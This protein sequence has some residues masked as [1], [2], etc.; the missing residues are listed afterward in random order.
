[1]EEAGIVRRG[2]N[3]CA[4]ERGIS[5][6]LEEP[7]PWQY[8]CITTCTTEARTGRASR[9]REGLPKKR[10]LDNTL[11]R[12]HQESPYVGHKKQSNFFIDGYQQ[13]K[14]LHIYRM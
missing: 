6:E 9:G 4:G 5:C 2:I 12:R 8:S 14:T 1:M 3:T 7:L 11:A 13:I 10:S